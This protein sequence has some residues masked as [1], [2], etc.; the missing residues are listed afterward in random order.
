MICSATDHLQQ[1]WQMEFLLQEMSEEIKNDGFIKLICN[2]VLGIGKNV[3]LLHLLGKLHLVCEATG[4][5]STG[6]YICFVEPLI[7]I[8]K[9]A[10]L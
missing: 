6:M 2:Q 5:L 8:L 1:D 3:H 4:N 7:L 10:M 9:K